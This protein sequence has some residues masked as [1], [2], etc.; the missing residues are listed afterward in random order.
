MLPLITFFVG[1]CFGVFITI[2]YNLK[3]KGVDESVPL[4]AFTDDYIPDNYHSPI[5]YTTIERIDL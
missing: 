5:V 2:V 3:P 4:E 1:F